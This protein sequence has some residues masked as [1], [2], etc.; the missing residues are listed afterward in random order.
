MPITRAGW[1][2]DCAGDRSVLATV[3]KPTVGLSTDAHARV[4]EEA[5]RGGVDLLKDDENLTDQAFNP[6]EDR[7][8]ESL[9]ARDRSRTTSASARPPS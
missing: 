3:P 1:Y 9:A 8:V 2:H 5:W 4:G 6:F 7:L